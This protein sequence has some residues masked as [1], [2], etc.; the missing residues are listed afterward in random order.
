MI[1]WQ[2]D[3]ACKHCSQ[4]T[5]RSRCTIPDHIIIT[6]IEQA[7]QIDCDLIGFTGGEAFLFYK[8]LLKINELCKK[9]GIKATVVTNANW[10]STK[11]ICIDRLS[12]LTAFSKITISHDPWHKEFV[13]PEKVA[14]AV[15]ACNLLGKKVEIATCYLNSPEAAELYVR[16]SLYGLVPDCINVSS[17]PIMW[18]GRAKYN[19]NKKDLF[20]YP[21]LKCRCGASQTPLLTP[22]GTLYACCGAARDIN[23][24]NF[25]KLGSLNTN[26]LNNIFEAAKTN[27]GLQMLRLKGPGALA[28]HLLRIGM[29]IDLA[30]IT[31]ICDICIAISNNP[32]SKHYLSIL[33][34]DDQFMRELAVSKLLFDYDSV[35]LSNFNE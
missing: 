15:T 24:N 12:N 2:C 28:N 18:R 20:Q 8:L 35:P 6:F 29:D 11:K 33:A 16:K 21:I 3:I 26:S 22:D 32:S 30:N 31:G 1:T 25:L 10:C 34:N 17:Q 23:N 19:F 13:P 7:A 9:N 27:H 4:G 5:A 14:N